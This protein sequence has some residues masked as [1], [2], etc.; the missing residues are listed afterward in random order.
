MAF[1][2]LTAPDRTGQNTWAQSVSFTTEA[3]VTVMTCPL[4]NCETKALRTTE[5]LN[6]LRTE[7]VMRYKPDKSGFYLGEKSRTLS[8]NTPTKKLRKNRAFCLQSS[9]SDVS[10]SVSTPSPSYS[11]SSLFINS[12]TR[13]MTAVSRTVLY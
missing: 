2:E 1:R 12:T 7:H 4:N 8:Y 11:N 10:V 3:T 6:W 9:Y 5:T 13:L